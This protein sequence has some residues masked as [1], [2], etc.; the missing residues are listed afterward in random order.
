MNKIRT[1]SISA[2][3]AALL[4][5][6][7]VSALS[8]FAMADVANKQ[9]KVTFS[10][11]VEI[12]GKVLPAGTYTFRILDNV[13]ARNVVEILNKGGQHLEAMLLTIPSYLQHPASGTIIRFQERPSNTP[14]AV[15][16]WWYPGD[17]YGRQFVYP[18]EEALQ[19]AKANREPVLSMRSNKSK[20]ATPES[21]Q[22]EKVTAVGPN[23][24]EVATEQALGKKKSQKSSQMNASNQ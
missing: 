9:T 1:A 24:N 4:V 10:G 20:N 22:N 18:R 7:L 14:Q 19:L 3:M 12:P 23:G 5:A 15:K 16:A 11:P 21:L 2:G 13:R 8:P 6:V 17:N